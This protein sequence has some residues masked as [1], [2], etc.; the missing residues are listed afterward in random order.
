[1][2]WWL[3]TMTLRIN[4]A[5][6]WGESGGTLVRI[7]QKTAKIET[8]NGRQTKKQTNKKAGPWRL[9]LARSLKKEQDWKPYQSLRLRWECYM[10]NFERTITK[11]LMRICWLHW[12]WL[13]P[14]SGARSWVGRVGNCTTNFVLSHATSFLS[15]SSACQ[16][17]LKLLIPA[18]KIKD[19]I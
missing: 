1:M 14:Y 2:T 12:I 9:A 5:R 19:F 3:A 13:L 6:I 7:W 10:L 15:L 18:L 4:L 11:Y 16:P 17:S 8:N